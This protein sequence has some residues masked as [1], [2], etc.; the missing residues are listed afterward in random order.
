M[1]DFLGI[2][3]EMIGTFVT[4]LVGTI[5]GAVKSIKFIQ[6]GEKG[7]RLRFGKAT[8][9]SNGVPIIQEPGF[10]VLIPFMDTLM[11]RHVRQQTLEFNGQRVMI[12]DGLIFQVKSILLFRVTDVYKALFE[13]DDLGKSVGDI[14]MAL[15]RKELSERDYTQLMSPEVAEHVLT[16]L[17]ERSSP[18]GLE[19]IQFSLVE[20]APTPETSNLLNATLAAKFRADALKTAAQ[21]LEVEVSS[22]DPFLAGVLVGLPLVAAVTSEGSKL[23]SSSMVKR[24]NDTK[25]K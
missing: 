1:L 2:G 15:L 7:I 22:I 25:D 3:P 11:R 5:I 21:E 20:A 16:Q 13:F 9:E 14:C 18:W 24:V 19:L 4:A 10:I 17:K 8:R 6:E 12:K 23:D